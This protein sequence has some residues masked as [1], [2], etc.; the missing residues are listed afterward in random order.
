MWLYVKFIFVTLNCIRCC[1]CEV[2]FALGIL[3]INDLEN[4]KKKIFMQKKKKK[5]LCKLCSECKKKKW[6]VVDIVVIRE[7]FGCYSGFTV[8]FVIT[9]LTTNKN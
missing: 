9:A 4:E 8:I 3:I 5:N 7:E 2:L 6:F 1:C